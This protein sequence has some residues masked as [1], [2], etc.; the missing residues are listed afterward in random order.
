MKTSTKQHIIAQKTPTSHSI[1]LSDSGLYLE[2]TRP[3]IGAWKQEKG[4]RDSPEFFGFSLNLPEFFGQNIFHPTH[5]MFDSWL[6]SKAKLSM[7]PTR[8]NCK[9]HLNKHSLACK[10]IAMQGINKKKSPLAD[11]VNELQGRKRKNLSLNEDCIELRGGR[12]K[13]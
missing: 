5:P 2:T 3:K 12:I 1:S 11:D 7:S 6:P 9:Y 10:Y 8:E 13:D 4:T